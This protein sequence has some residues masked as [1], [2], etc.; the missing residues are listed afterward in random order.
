MS[1]TA[2]HGHPAHPVLLSWFLVGVSTVVTWVQDPC[3]A[4]DVL[5]TT[6]ATT[7]KRSTQLTH[8]LLRAGGSSKTRTSST[9]EEESES[10]SADDSTSGS[11]SSTGSGSDSEEEIRVLQKS[12]GKSGAKN[13]KRSNN[14]SV[15]SRRSGGSTNGS[16]RGSNHGSTHGSNTQLVSRQVSTQSR[17]SCRAFRN[18][19]GVITVTPCVSELIQRSADAAVELTFSYTWTPS[20]SDPT[21]PSL[22][23]GHRSLDQG[24]RQQN[25]AIEIKWNALVV[26]GHLYLNVPNGVGVERN[27]EA[28]VTLLE[29]AEEEL[30]CTHI[31]V[32]FSKTRPE[33]SE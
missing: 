21:H 26:K 29:F 18:G 23:P 27:K 11:E 30:A 7:G 5:N 28:F 2:S 24:H 8:H 17:D 6:T 19:Y 1:V 31:I 12:G 20:I 13:G 25:S 10:S 33:R 22:D 14:A 15:G 4:P 32:C 3:G 9:A 16:T